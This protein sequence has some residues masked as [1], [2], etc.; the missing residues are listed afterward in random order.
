MHGET[1]KIIVNNIYVR[2]DQLLTIPKFQQLP[3]VIGGES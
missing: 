1:I 2:K 3:A